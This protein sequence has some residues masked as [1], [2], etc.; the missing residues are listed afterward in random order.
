MNKSEN[1]KKAFDLA[2][3][4]YAEIGVNVEDAM[5]KLDNFPISMHCWQAD[6]V[7]GFETPDSELS[8]GGIQATGNYPGKAR[9][10]EV[11]TWESGSAPRVAA[12]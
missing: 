1:I 2:R 6:D 11:V 9:T 12:G 7:G 5:K 4:K 8:G 3:S 10:K